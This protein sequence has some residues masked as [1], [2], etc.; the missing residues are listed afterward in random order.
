MSQSKNQYYLSGALL[1]LQP[2]TSRPYTTKDGRTV[3]NK[4]RI[5]VVRHKM[6]K[7]GKWAINDVTLHCT[8]DAV[9]QLE[10]MQPGLEVIA[11]FSIEVIAW[12]PKGEHEEK[13]FQKLTCN[14]IM[15][16]TDKFKSTKWWADENRQPSR[17]KKTSAEEKEDDNTPRLSEQEQKWKMPDKGEYHVKRY[18]KGDDYSTDNSKEIKEKVYAKPK[19]ETPDDDLPF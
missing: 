16:P 3:E 15:S 1:L 10:L 8:R 11:D 9:E 13:R 17:V 2:V 7:Y 6:S 18:N 14:K 12:T 19:E 5:I 4:E